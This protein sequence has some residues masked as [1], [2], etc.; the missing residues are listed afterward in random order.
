MGVPSG[1]RVGRGRTLAATIACAALLGLGACSAASDTTAPVPGSSTPATTAPAAPPSSSP[2]ATAGTTSSTASSAAGSA[3][4][5][6]GDGSAFCATFE[7]LGTR[8]A[9]R[10]GTNDGN[11][12]QADWE[13]NL[14]TVKKIAEAAPAAIAPEAHAYVQ[15]VE[16][17]YELARNNG[18]AAIADLPAA[19]RDAFIAEHRTMQADVNELIAYAKANC[20]AFAATNL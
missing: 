16:D 19:E 15:M 3:T 20:P 14:V 1:S 4:E 12:N 18:Y 8:R 6:T 17:R 11:R 9:E 13:Q 2:A 10:G 5:S 7:G